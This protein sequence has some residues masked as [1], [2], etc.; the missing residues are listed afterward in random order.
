ML[1]DGSV[2]CWGFG[3]DGRLGYGNQS[4]IG[5]DETPAKAGRVPL[6]EGRTARAISA[7]GAHTCALLDDGSVRC[8]GTNGQLFG[9]DGRLG[10]G[11]A[12][13]IGNSKT[14][15]DVDPVDLG[16]GR[17]AR[18]IS[19]GDFHTCAVLDDRSVRCWGLG[20]DGRLGYGHTRRIGDDE[21]PGS[22]GPVN[23]GPG[24]TATAISAGG[25]SCAR[26]DNG[27]VRCWGPGTAG[28]LGYG[29]TRNIGDG[30]TPDTAGPVDLGPGRTAAAIS[31]GASHSC[32]LLDDSS[33]GCWGEG[34]YGRLGYGNS[35][36]IGDDEAPAAAGPVAIRTRA[37]IADA[38]VS[39]GDGGEAT[40]TDGS[41]AADVAALRGEASRRRGLRACLARVGRHARREAARARRLSG[42]RRARTRRHARRHEASLRRACLKRFGRTPG[43]VTGLGARA[44]GRGRIVLTFR[45]PGTDGRRP[46][47]ARSYVVKQSRRPIR[48]A[49]QFRRAGSLCG[50]ACR[51]PK[52]TRVGSAITLDVAD[53]RPGAAYYYA[54]AARD[55]VSGRPGPRSR[56]ARARARR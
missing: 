54:I 55:N 23:L 29:D 33:L 36:N 9:G 28:Q 50:G 53:L 19:A 4:S 49:R 51:F 42:P 2:R 3:Q 39:E 43:R 16:D 1:D 14:P 30:E 13:I 10:Y 26:L 20:E 35:R 56:A 24:R 41:S 17:T 40:P 12:E 8:W 47:A 31:V 7:G 48:S 46:P 21:T 6:G 22:A 37:S 45:A 15:A 27:T 52:I 34:L 5:D 44:A 18:A 32:A 11:N 38:A 25:H